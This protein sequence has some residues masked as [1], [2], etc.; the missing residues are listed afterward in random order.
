VLEERRHSDQVTRIESLLI[1][2]KQILDF[3][4]VIHL[5]P[6]FQYPQE[7]SLPRFDS[8]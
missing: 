1:C 3:A 2:I 5:Y 7:V 6:R 4:A 8:P